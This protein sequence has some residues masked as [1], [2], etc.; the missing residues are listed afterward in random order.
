MVFPV[1]HGDPPRAGDAAPA[2]ATVDRDRPPGSQP[3]AVPAGGGADAVLRSLYAEHSASLRSQAQRML[4]DPHQA[5]DVVQET[6]LRAWRKLDTLNPERGSVGGWLRRVSYNIA[7][8]RLRAKRARP[9]EVDESYTS[10]AAS[11]VTDHADAAV[12]SAFVARALATLTPSHRAV[13]HQL[14]F[15]DRTCAEAAKV[16]GIREGTVKSRLYHALR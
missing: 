7:V 12:N 6:M 2:A 8:D 16:L 14:Y 4:S 3:A 10:T 13:L 9:P 1:L 5:E 15:A 11:S